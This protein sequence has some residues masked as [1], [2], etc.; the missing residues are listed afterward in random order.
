MGSD[1]P[2]VV[3]GIE[4]AAALL[5]LRVRVGDVVQPHPHADDLVS[6]LVEER[7]RDR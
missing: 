3:G 4:R 6:L 2:G 5:E 7:R 1:A